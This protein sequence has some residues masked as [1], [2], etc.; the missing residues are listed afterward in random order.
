MCFNLLVRGAWIFGLLMWLA[1]PL[2]HSPSG[3]PLD[4]HP[5]L[6][7]IS[8]A[9]PHLDTCVL[10][11]RDGNYHLERDHD[12]ATEVYEG[13]LSADE[14][15]RLQQWLDNE[16]LRK[17]TNEQIV[18]PLVIINVESLQLDI[19]RSDTLQELLFPSSES[20]GPFH[21]GLAPLLGW[22]DELHKAPHRTIPEDSGKNNC[23]TPGKIELKT[24][25]PASALTGQPA[26]SAASSVAPTSTDA[27]APLPVPGSYLMHF[28]YTR[29]EQREAQRTCAIVYADGQYHMEKSSQ[30]MNER[31]KWRI[32]EA[33]VEASALQELQRLLGDSALQSLKHGNVPDDSLFAATDIT[34]LWIPRDMET[35]DLQFATDL[36]VQA[37][38]GGHYIVNDKNTRL[39][40]PLQKWVNTELRADKINLVAGATANSCAPK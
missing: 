28:E 4:Q 24:R 3:A 10:L 1:L 6:L 9:T 40:R 15:S 29:F 11:K 18:T 33:S 27:K 2:P 5:Y 20:Q 23:L 37:A 22:F 39:V 14:L 17:L 34:H 30:E 21:E 8:R 35:Q 31:V 12:D 32:Y 36:R 16:Q 7:R 38:I 26:A 13:E 25:A 19:F